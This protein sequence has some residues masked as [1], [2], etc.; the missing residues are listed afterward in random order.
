MATVTAGPRYQAQ[1][2]TAHPALPSASA[3][4][5]SIPATKGRRTDWVAMAFWTTC[6]ALM[7]FL[8]LKDLLVSWFR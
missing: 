7:G 6:F 2:E 1:V 5:E 3:P 4:V 8:H